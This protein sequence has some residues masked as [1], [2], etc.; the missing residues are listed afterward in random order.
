MYLMK[1]VC[2]SLVPKKNKDHLHPWTNS[3]ITDYIVLWKSVKIARMKTP[4]FTQLFALLMMVHATM[5][6]YITHLVPKAAILTILACWIP[7]SHFASFSWHV[8]SSSLRRVTSLW[9]ACP[10]LPSL[11]WEPE[12]PISADELPPYPG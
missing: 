4:T 12:P 1:W 5:Q 3:S 2:S 6:T 8:A 9:P 11:Y 10:L 7:S